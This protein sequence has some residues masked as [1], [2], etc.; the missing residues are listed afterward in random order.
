MEEGRRVQAMLFMNEGCK[1]FLYRTRY[2]HGKL[3]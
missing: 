2:V 1:G 3:V